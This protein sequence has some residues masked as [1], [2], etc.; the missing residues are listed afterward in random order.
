LDGAKDG[1]PSRAMGRFK[2]ND[3]AGADDGEQALGS[4]PLRGCQFVPIF[5]GNKALPNRPGRLPFD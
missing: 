2:H 3:I 1:G 4:H 5:T